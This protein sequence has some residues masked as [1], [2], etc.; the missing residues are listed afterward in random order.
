MTVL[1]LRLS[2]TRVERETGKQEKWLDDQGFPS[3]KSKLLRLCFAV[4]DG[5]LL[6]LVARAL[7][8]AHEM[9]QWLVFPGYGMVA[10]VIFTTVAV[11]AQNM[12]AIIGMALVDSTLLGRARRQ[13]GLLGPCLSARARSDYKV[14]VCLVLFN[15]FLDGFLYLPVLV[16]LCVVFHQSS[17]RLT[18]VV[19]FLLVKMS[20]TVIAHGLSVCMDW[21]NDSR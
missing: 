18:I 3:S 10:A 8:G 2:R 4:A 11:V 20:T 14:V 15:M 19:C 5:V 17:Y 9:R 12:V 7:E 13:M 21:W 1:P 16:G 6:V